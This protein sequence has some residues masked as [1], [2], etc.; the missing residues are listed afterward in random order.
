MYCVGTM[1]TLTDKRLNCV[2]CVKCWVSQIIRLICACVTGDFNTPAVHICSS[3]PMYVVD[4]GPGDALQRMRRRKL[5]SQQS[6]HRKCTGTQEFYRFFFLYVQ[7]QTFL[8]F[9]SEWDL[10]DAILFPLLYLGLVLHMKNA[11]FW[12]VIPCDS[13]QNRRFGGT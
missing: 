12:D 10:L 11:V 9:L 13:C 6:E 1:M 4:F 8:R 3:Q 5:Q 7:Y 2:R